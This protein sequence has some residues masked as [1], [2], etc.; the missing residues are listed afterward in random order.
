MN[1]ICDSRDCIRFSETKAYNNNNEVEQKNDETNKQKN[2]KVL[3]PAHA[4]HLLN[5]WLC[6]LLTKKQPNIYN[7]TCIYII[8]LYYMSYCGPDS[9]CEIVYVPYALCSKQ[10][11]D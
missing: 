1:I 11:K 5:G 4:V 6:A 9:D 10:N 7:T 8:I 3:L 2:R